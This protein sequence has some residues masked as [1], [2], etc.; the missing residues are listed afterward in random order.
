MAPALPVQAGAQSHAGAVKQDSYVSDRLRQNLTHVGGGQFLYLPQVKDLTL[1]R[2]Q[3]FHAL[4]DCL[5][6]LSSH[7]LTIRGRGR[8]TPIASRVELSLELGVDG[9]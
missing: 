2:R 9:V 8:P 7:V 5:P 6:R 1:Q 4:Q 3:P